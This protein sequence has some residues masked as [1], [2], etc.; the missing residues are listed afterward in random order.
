[1]PARVHWPEVVN[2]G[3]L[4]MLQV[5][6]AALRQCSQSQVP[7]H[8]CKEPRESEQHLKSQTITARW[9]TCELKK[10]RTVSPSSNSSMRPMYASTAEGSKRRND[11]FLIYGVHSPIQ[12]VIR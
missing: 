1:M 3:L 2:G 9:R 8:Q 4:V 5:S 7:M 10:D 12:T 11:I 6:I